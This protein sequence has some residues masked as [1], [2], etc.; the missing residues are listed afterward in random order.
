M[1]Q[2]GQQLHQALLLLSQQVPLAF[3][4]DCFPGIQSMHHKP[5]ASIAL[6][7]QHEAFHLPARLGGVVQPDLSGQLLSVE[8]EH[9]QIHHQVPAHFGLAVLQQAQCLVE[10][11]IHAF[12]NG[13]AQ[14]DVIPGQHLQ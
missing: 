6:R 11:V 2:F 14:G 9:A 3:G 5:P 10:L 1:Q 8:R 7:L 12:C 13:C 4:R